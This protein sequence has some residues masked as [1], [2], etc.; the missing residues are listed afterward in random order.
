MKIGKRW[1]GP[2]WKQS[3]F[4]QDD[5]EWWRKKID[6]YDYH[7]ENFLYFNIMNANFLFIRSFAIDIVLWILIEFGPWK[8]I[9]IGMR[10]CWWFFSILEL[11]I[12]HQTS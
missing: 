9:D 3:E 7:Y 5:E 8:F 11:Y 4:V 1:K 2:K 6:Q 12:I 10:C